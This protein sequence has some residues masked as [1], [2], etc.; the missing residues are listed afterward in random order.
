MVHACYAY[1]YYYAIYL[2]C[3][4]SSIDFLCGTT[5]TTTRYFEEEV[6]AGMFDA[7]GQRVRRRAT[8]AL[9]PVQYINPIPKEQKKVRDFSYAERA[10]IKRPAKIKPCVV[11][12]DGQGATRQDIARCFAVACSNAGPYERVDLK[13]SRQ[14]M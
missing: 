2:C 3:S 13:I 12:L 5:T 10:L 4:S 7:D 14:T 9:Q 1:Y 8:G 11:G 6:E